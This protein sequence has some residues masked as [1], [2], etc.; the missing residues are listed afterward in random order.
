MSRTLPRVE[1]WGEEGTG[2]FNSWNDIL[3]LARR[4]DGSFSIRLRRHGIDHPGVST[5]YRSGPF[6][7]PARFLDELQHRVA[8]GAGEQLDRDFNLG[9]VINMLAQ[10]I[11]FEPTLAREALRL[12]ARQIGEGNIRGASCSSTSLESEKR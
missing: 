9:D 4:K 1:L 5:I 10:S 11:D 8:E 12:L 6:R 2:A 3:E 7:T